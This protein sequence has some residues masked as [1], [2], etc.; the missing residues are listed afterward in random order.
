MKPAKDKSEL[1]VYSVCTNKCECCKILKEK[2]T[3][4][5]KKLADIEN[6][7]NNKINKLK[8][9]E[10][11]AELLDKPRVFDEITYLHDWIEQLEELR[12]EILKRKEVKI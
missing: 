3:E 1:K 2:E 9:I 6:I 4:R 10:A 8:K 11:V 7:I 12:E 5:E